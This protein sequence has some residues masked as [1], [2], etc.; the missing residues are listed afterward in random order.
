[1]AWCNSSWLQLRSVGPAIDGRNRVRPQPQALCTGIG[2]P[3]LQHLLLSGDPCRWRAS[4]CP[5]A[6]QC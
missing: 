3:A 4:T 6:N 1:M 2:L 5:L